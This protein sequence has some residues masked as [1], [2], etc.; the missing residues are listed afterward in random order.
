MEP[1][2]SGEG[3]IPSRSKREPQ[4]AEHGP[5]CQVAEGWKNVLAHHGLLNLRGGG[6]KTKVI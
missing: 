1:T 3:L 2:K 6:G 5:D 4:P